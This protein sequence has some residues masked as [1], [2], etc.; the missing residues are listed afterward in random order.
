MKTW[1]AH[2]HETKPPVLLKE[3]FSW[4]GAL[5]GPLWLLARRAWIPAAL[6]VALYA[7]VA[8]LSG[9]KLT[10]VAWLL[11]NWCLGLFG[12]DLLRW[13]LRLRGFT[14]AH[15]V[16]ARNADGAFMRLLSARPDLADL[17]VP[18]LLAKAGKI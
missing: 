2:L 4:A 5:F 7:A 8:V 11:G 9:E 6:A 15:V 17:F 1:T 12:H 10:M 16:A 18:D 13:N 14:L 3:G